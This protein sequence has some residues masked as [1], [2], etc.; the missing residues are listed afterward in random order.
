MCVPYDLL[1]VFIVLSIDL[2][3]HKDIKV[4]GTDTHLSAIILNINNGLNSYTKRLNNFF[5][6]EDTSICVKAVYKTWGNSLPTIH[7]RISV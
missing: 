4:T 2:R 3:K 1:S 5:T 7:L 6:A